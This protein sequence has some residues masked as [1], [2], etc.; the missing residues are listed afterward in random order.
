MALSADFSRVGAAMTHRHQGLDLCCW[1]TSLEM[2]MQWRHKCI[3]GV[4]AQRN[5][6]TEH[7]KA[8]Q[9]AYRRNR[10]YEISSCA[11]D[12]G[13]KQANLTGSNWKVKL[14]LSPILLTGNYGM[15]RPGRFI[16]IKCGHVILAIGLS[17]SNKVV[18][19]DPFRTGW[20][21]NNYIYMTQE[22]AWSRLDKTRGGVPDAWTTQDAP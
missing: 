10:G 19:L 13:L 4:D 9:D 14:L 15:A 20:N 7:T 2:L 12:Y 22:E 8:V 11:A 6:R 1:M 21:A 16:G 17:N 18:Y 3:Y 5:K